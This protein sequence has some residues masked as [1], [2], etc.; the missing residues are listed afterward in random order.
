M[1][2][3]L[4]NPHISPTLGQAVSSHSLEAV[5]GG[6]AENERV[7]RESTHGGERERLLQGASL[8]SPKYSVS[9]KQVLGDPMSQRISESVEG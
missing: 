2:G 3:F 6:A 8:L 5:S 9:E 4:G 1:V 7:P